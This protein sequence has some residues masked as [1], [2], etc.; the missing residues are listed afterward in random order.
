MTPI[1]D[2]NQEDRIAALEKGQ[3]EILELLRPISETYTSVSLMGK[4]LMAFMVLISI[5]LGIVLSVGKLFNK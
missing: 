1:N 2:Q 5:L 3:R 4:W